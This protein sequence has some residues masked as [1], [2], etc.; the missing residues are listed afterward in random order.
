ML[1]AS[2]GDVVNALGDVAFP[3]DKET[4]VEGAVAAGASGDVVAALRALPP[5]QYGSR[6]EVARSVIVDP[7]ADRNL[8]PAQLAEQARLGG[9][10]GQSQHVREVPKPPVEDEMDR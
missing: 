1:H 2:V 9:R 7:E 8:S 5:E 4:L 6:D 3:A 10:P